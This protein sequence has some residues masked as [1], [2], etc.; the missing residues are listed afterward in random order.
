L[1]N[2]FFCFINFQ[3]F[4]DNFTKQRLDPPSDEEPDSPDEPYFHEPQCA[5]DMWTKW[6]DLDSAADEGDYETL[7]KIQKQCPESICELPIDIQGRVAGSDDVFSSADD[8]NQ[9]VELNVQI[10]LICKNEG[11]FCD[12]YEVRFCCPRGMLVF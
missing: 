9:Q 7:L 3:F 6:F 5:P 2:N 8:F 11:Q 10:G 1:E 4:K 12:N